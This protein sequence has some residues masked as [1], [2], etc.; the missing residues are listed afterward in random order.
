M[1]QRFWNL[2]LKP[3]KSR[4]DPPPPTFR[5]LYPPPPPP[6]SLPPPPPSPPPP[7]T[8]PPP[9]S[10][11]RS[12]LSPQPTATGARANSRLHP[13]TDRGTWVRHS[14]YL[15]FNQIE[16][17][18]ALL[19]ENHFHFSFLYFNAYKKAFGNVHREMKSECDFS[20]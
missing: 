14:S 10:H 9:P 7:P 16:S 2:S 5:A 17:V 18:I 1:D 4:E 13:E 6:P 8:P 15:G 3:S 20:L 12:H 11:Q 19:S